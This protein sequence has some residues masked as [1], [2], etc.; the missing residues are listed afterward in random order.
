MWCACL[1]QH[2]C[3]FKWNP[4]PWGGVGGREEK[5]I[6]ATTPLLLYLRGNFSD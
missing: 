5:G 3:T 1:R 2:W 6:E 4:G